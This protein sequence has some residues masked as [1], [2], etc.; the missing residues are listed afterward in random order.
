V[1][2]WSLSMYSDQTDDLHPMLRIN[3]SQREAVENV[4]TWTGGS[5]IYD[6]LGR[7]VTEP[8]QHG[9]YI[10]NGQKIIR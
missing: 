10:Q 4:R 1:T 3:S 8:S 9:V 7:P 5:T 6:I 2:R